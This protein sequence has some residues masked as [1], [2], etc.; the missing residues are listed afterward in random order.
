MNSKLS[1][2]DITKELNKLGYKSEWIFGTLLV[3]SLLDNWRVEEYVDCKGK[4]IFKILH[5]NKRVVVDGKKKN[6]FRYHFQCYRNSLEG[7]IESIKNHD[8]YILEEQII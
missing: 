3:E 7:V 6:K 1:K 4:L 2:E 8:N 5:L